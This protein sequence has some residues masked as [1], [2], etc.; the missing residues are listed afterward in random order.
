M[1]GAQ[2][3]SVEERWNQALKKDGRMGKERREA[4][5]LLQKLLEE[6]MTNE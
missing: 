1:C 6:K 4:A 5:F 3:H 2:N